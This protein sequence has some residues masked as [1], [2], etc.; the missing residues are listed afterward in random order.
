MSSSFLSTS[1][2]SFRRPVNTFVA[3]V[4]TVQKSSMMDLAETLADINPV[5]QNFI[6]QKA[7]QTNERK[8]AEGQQFIL[9]ADNETIKKALKVINDKDGERA[10]RDFLGNNKFFK[11]GVERLFVRE[12]TCKFLW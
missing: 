9:E 12:A 3:P 11:I 8:I 6:V 2:E 10:K 4:D 1:G 5:L 7:K